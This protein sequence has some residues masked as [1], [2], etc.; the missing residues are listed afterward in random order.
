MGPQSPASPP[1]PS[2]LTR[3]APT[4]TPHQG[5]PRHPYRR[6]NNASPH[7]PQTLGIDYQSLK[8]NISCPNP[9]L[10]ATM[11]LPDPSL[12]EDDQAHGSLSLVSF[13]VPPQ[14]DAKLCAEKGTHRT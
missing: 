13:V 5:L 10:N 4:T 9:P 14:P 1:A 8:T 6:H 12:F 11:I 2:T 3:L 7:L